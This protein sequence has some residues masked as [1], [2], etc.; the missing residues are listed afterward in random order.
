M[1]ISLGISLIVATLVTGSGVRLGILYFLAGSIGVLTVGR[2]RHR[3]EFYRS[4]FFIPFVMAVAVVSTNDW[5]TDSP[6]AQVG[7]DMFIAAINGFFC[8]I[9]A[10]GLLPLLESIFRIVTDITLLEI[11][12]AYSVFA[13]QG[14]LAGQHEFSPTSNDN[15]NHVD[16]VSVISVKYSVKLIFLNADAC[17]RHFYDDI[18]IVGGSD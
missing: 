7:K 14:A 1:L 8:P 5:L 15:T 9:I 17:I 18:M 11:T 4:M 12:Q 16:P 13:N 3:K 10:I 6:A 2:V